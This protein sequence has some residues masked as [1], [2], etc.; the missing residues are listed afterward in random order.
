MTGATGS[1]LRAP[2]LYHTF[3]R[4]SLLEI[5]QAHFYFLARLSVIKNIFYVYLT[6][7]LRKETQ[8][9]L[10]GLDDLL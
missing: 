8:F 2:N 7:I 5:I 3:F 10:A 1:K 4:S 9:L 6:S